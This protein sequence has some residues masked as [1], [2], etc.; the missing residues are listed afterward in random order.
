M[1]KA[2]FSDTAYQL[3][4]QALE[5]SSRRA[6]VSEWDDYVG[7]LKSLKSVGKQDAQ[8]LWELAESKA[9]DLEKAQIRI[10][11]ECVEQTSWVP[12][13]LE[14]VV[15]TRRWLQSLLKEA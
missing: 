10:L 1:M 2:E 7:L 14:D 4:F 3:C 6:A 8:G 12:M 15:A 9:L 13:K 11:V 5:Y